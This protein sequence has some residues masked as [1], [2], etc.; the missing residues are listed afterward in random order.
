MSPVSWSQHIIHGKFTPKAGSTEMPPG[1]QHIHH[2]QPEKST[3]GVWEQ[4]HWSQPLTAPASQVYLAA[5]NQHSPPSNFST[6]TDSKIHQLST[7]PNHYGNP[8]F[9]TGKS[10]QQIVIRSVDHTGYPSP[11]LG[12]AEWATSSPSSPTP[13]HQAE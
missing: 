1:T 9:I 3:S 8:Y 11:S 6:L 7:D 12:F 4:Q 13:S 2:S 5:S 10:P